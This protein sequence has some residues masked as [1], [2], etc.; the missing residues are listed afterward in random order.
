M[1]LFFIAAAAAAAPP[2]K[3]FGPTTLRCS[4]RN[5]FDSDGVSVPS[6]NW[7]KAL[8]A[9]TVRDAAGVLHS[10]RSQTF[11]PEKIFCTL[12]TRSCA[13]PVDWISSL[14]LH[15]PSADSCLAHCF[16]SF[17]VL[18]DVVFKEFLVFTASV[19]V[20]LAISSL[21]DKE[22]FDLPI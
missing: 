13:S 16:V 2:P 4:P 6:K 7:Q 22:F 20:L 8:H 5:L 18:L 9:L 19:A 21:V 17:H 3:I 10:C 15:C 12:D 1:L 11:C 14:E